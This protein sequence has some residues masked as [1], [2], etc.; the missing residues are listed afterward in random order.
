MAAILLSLTNGPA[1]ATSSGTTGPAVDVSAT[2]GRLEFMAK[3]YSVAP[4]G[5]GTAAFKLQTSMV[6]STDASDWEDVSGATVSIT[7]ANKAKGFS[8]STG[9]K[10]YVR[11]SVDLTTWTD[12]TY[13]VPG[14]GW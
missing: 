5:G 3:V 11:Y 6:N 8:A 14:L 4:A 1:R 7:S 12:I 13:D 10:R 9:V 2:G